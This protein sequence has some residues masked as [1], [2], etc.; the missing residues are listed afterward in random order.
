MSTQANED[1]QGT[2]WWST[3]MIDEATDEHV[4]KTLSEN[5]TIGQI[6]R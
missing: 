3:K 5:E 6:K 4:N 2:N 1:T